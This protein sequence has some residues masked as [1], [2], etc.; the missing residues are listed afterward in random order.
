MIHRI[1]QPSLI[2]HFWM[3]ASLTGGRGGWRRH[4]QRSLHSQETHSLSQVRCCLVKSLQMQVISDHLE[5]LSANEQAMCLSV[6]SI[7]AHDLTRWDLFG[8]CYRLLRTGIEHGSM[9][10]QVRLFQIWETWGN[11]MKPIKNMSRS[12]F[13]TNLNKK[14][15]QDKDMKGNYVICIPTLSS[16]QFSFL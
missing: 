2:K 6:L 16:W 13:N 4:L 12:H 5:S 15:Y 3:S 8:N 9:P 7:S 11:L 10:E 14:W 1:V